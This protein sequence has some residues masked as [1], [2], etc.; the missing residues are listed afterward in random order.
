[1]NGS[2]MP[3]AFSDLLQFTPIIDGDH[4]R[5][6]AFAHSHAG[7]TTTLREKAVR[8]F[9]AV[10]DGIR[11]DPYTVNLT[12]NGMRA[13]NTLAAGRAWCVPKAVLLAACC[14]AMGIPAGLGFADVRNHLTTERLKKA[15]NT[16]IFFWHGYTTIYIG[17]KWVKATPAFNIELCERFRLKPLEFDG[18]GDSLFQP[19]D[20]LGNAHMEYI[21]YRGEFSDAPLDRINAT[22]QRHYRTMTDLTTC[23]FDE[24]AQQ[25]HPRPST[26]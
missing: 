19:F 1:M 21:R 6:N 18:T 4:E 25:E 8:L 15:M 17:E 20:L 22:F 3:D 2:A 26:P 13:S 12:T 24:D 5:V 10:R 9:Y 14:R 16:D 11:Y 7:G 23:D